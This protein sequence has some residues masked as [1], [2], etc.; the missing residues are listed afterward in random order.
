MLLR[1]ETT[2]VER[3]A[4]HPGHLS[5]AAPRRVHA[6]PTRATLVPYLRRLGVTPPPLLAA[7]A[8]AAGST[9][10][11]DVV[12]PTSSIPSSAPRRFRRAGRRRSGPRRWASCWTSC[13]T[14]WR[15]RPRTGL[16][17]RAR[18]RPGLA[19]TRAGSTSSGARGSRS[20][21]AACSCRSWATRVRWC[22]SGA[23]S[24][25]CRSAAELRVRYLE[26]AFP[27]D[28]STCPSCSASA[29]ARR[30]GWAPTTPVAAPWPR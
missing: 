11:Y 30:D 5:A 23:R 17:R 19:A 13:P 3:D 9:H 21:T 8:L 22:S 28:P 20:S 18:P 24:R 4:G 1:H 10:G 2:A 6:S 26:H 14:T 29:G 25:S 16:G 7:P 15:R 12:D 27:L